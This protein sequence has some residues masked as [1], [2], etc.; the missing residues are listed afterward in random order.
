MG[1]APRSPVP[2][3]VPVPPGHDRRAHREPGTGA[4]DATPDATPGALAR[5]HREPGTG[6]PG[7]GHH[8]PRTA[9]P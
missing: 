6:A 2:V 8:G 4:P 1:R 9:T 5:A 3:P 7:A